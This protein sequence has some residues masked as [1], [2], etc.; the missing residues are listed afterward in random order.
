MG[1]LR[2]IHLLE[3]TILLV[4][5]GP[6]R[7]IER[8]TRRI[9]V[10]WTGTTANGSLMLL[11]AHLVTHHDE[12][13]GSK[14]T[15]LTAVDNPYEVQ[16]ATERISALL[17][18]ARIDAEI[19]VILSN[20]R[21]LYEVVS[22]ESGRADLVFLGFLLPTNLRNAEGFFHRMNRIMSGLPR[23]ILVS[24]ARGHDFESVVFD[25]TDE[26]DAIGNGNGNGNN[27]RAKPR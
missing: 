15:V 18:A 27:R 9:H 6:D 14:I 26:M 4:R 5:E 23:T 13:A 16:E 25:S 24:S 8:R 12:W 7:V 10:W 2:D 22:G 21:P 17:Q 20:G 1:M 19:D 11:L 3:R